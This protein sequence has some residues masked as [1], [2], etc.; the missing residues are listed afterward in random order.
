MSSVIKDFFD[1]DS[2]TYSYVVHCLQTQQAAVI[3]PVLNFDAASGRTN[4]QGAQA[5]IDYIQQHQLQLCWILETHVHADHLSAAPLLKQQL[6]GRTAIGRQI[7]QVQQLFADVFQ[8]EPEFCK[9]GRQFDKLLDDQEQ[10][11]L[12]EL[13]IQVLFTPGHT[14]ACVSFLIGDAVFVGDTLFMP[15]YGSARCDF[16]GGSAETLYQ[17]AQRLFALPKETRMFLCHDYKAQGREVFCGQTTIEAQ[18][19]SNIHLHQGISQSEF[20]QMRT[21]RDATL[22][23][24]KLMLPAVQVNMRAGHFPPAEANG[25]HYLKLPINR[26]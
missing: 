25:V 1:I 16:P 13:T 10:L 21:Q 6:G 5:I 24:P 14:P 22:S 3:D 11:A 18:L 7:T 2:N 4:S 12:G 17:S 19:S 8:A 15:D 9:D 26:F 20:V 23:M